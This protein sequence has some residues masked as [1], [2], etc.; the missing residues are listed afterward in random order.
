[1]KMNFHDKEGLERFSDF[2]KHPDKV[3]IKSEFGSL[4]EKDIWEHYDNPKVKKLLISQFEDK[5]TFL[6]VCINGTIFKRYPDSKEEFLQ[7]TKKNYDKINNGGNC[8]MHV[9]LKDKNEYGWV[10]FDPKEK[11]SFEELKEVVLEV[12]D[13]LIRILEGVD[14]IEIFFSGGKGFHLYIYFK[15]KKDVD[16][17]RKLLKVLL[18]IYI[19]ESGR[20]NL[21]TGVTHNSKMCRLDVSTLKKS[22][23]IRAIYSLNAT[24]GLVKVP[25]EFKEVK[26]FKKEDA[27]VTK[28]LK[29]LSWRKKYLRSYSSKEKE[30]QISSLE[31]LD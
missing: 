10:D 29:K 26:K 1:M 18:D 28:V 12:Y 3:K 21:T 8:E 20:G 2:P 7:V 6:V 4:T 14:R 22:G 15:H 24:T 9:G 17:L 11:F 19:E 23:S 30:S 13:Y 16:N 27:T 5:Y 31:G 25:I